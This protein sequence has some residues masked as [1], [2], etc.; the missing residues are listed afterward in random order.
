MAAVTHALLVAECSDAFD[1]GRLLNRAAGR[2]PEDQPHSQLTAALGLVVVTDLKAQTLPAADETLTWVEETCGGYLTQARGLADAL[3]ADPPTEPLAVLRAWNDIQVLLGN[4]AAIAG[5]YSSVDPAA[6]VRDAADAA[7]QPLDAFGTEL[8]MDAKLFEIISAV[9]ASALDADAQRLLERT[10]RDFRRSGVDR[11][12]VTRARLAELAEAELKASQEHNKNIRE[13]VRSIHVTPDALAGMPQDWL[14]AH[15]ADADG[16][17]TVTTDYP[18]SIPLVTF[19]SDHGTRRVLT[20]ERLNV[21]WPAND[22][23]LQR[24]LALR[25]EHAKLLGYDSWADYDAE[26]KMIGSASAI[27]EFIDKICDAA[28]DS[29]LRDKQVLLDRLRR[30]VPDA[31][32]IDSPD[33]SYYSELVRKEDYSVDAQLVRTYFD[34]TKVRQGLLD[35]TGR[36]FGLRFRAAHV[37]TWHEDVAAYDVLRDDVVI[38]RIYLDLHPREGKYKHAAQFDLRSGVRGRQLPEGV[39]VCNFSRGLMEHSDVVTLFHEF[40][41]L[42]HH[43]LG[44]D[45]EWVRFSGVATEWDFV[46]APSQMLEEWAWDAD[47]LATFAINADGETIPADLV[48]RMRRA[49][50]FGKGFQARTQMFYAALSLQIHLESHDDLTDVVRELQGRYSV[51][52]YVED[53]HFHCAFGHLD[54]Y[55]SGYYTYMWSLVIAKDMFSAFDDADLFAPAV[56]ER[57]R[58]CVLVQGGRKDAADLVADFLGRSYTFD[59][60]ARWLAE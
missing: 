55:S 12:D 2:R 6:Q 60:Y 22:A 42:I 31:T 27:G 44:G 37:V 14:D 54:G 13:G 23:V 39:L 57:Y 10:L 48:E 49:D 34:F 3:R 38:G 20:R 43:V 28:T 40:G 30:D 56:A 5:L 8:G 53:T 1:M 50:D 46:E 52:P 32:D 17:V 26:V 7:M 16:L 25:A 41:H 58:D 45:Q 9:D 19:C 51:F 59:A 11:D 33:L 4:A 35:V 21:A 47:V 36:L 18:D 24:L 29:A 15:P